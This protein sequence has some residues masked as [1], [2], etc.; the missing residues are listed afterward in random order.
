VKVRPALEQA[1]GYCFSDATLLEAALTHR[2]HSH[3]QGAGAA[4]NYERLE[5]LGDAL[6]GFLVADW[7]YR[8]DPPVSEGVL[9]RRRQTI[10]RQATLAE[11]AQGLGLGEA[12]RLGRGEES[13]GGRSKASLLADVFES[14]LGA[15]YLDGGIRPARAFV[16]RHLGS[17]L[18]VVRRS[19]ESRD[20]HKTRLQEAIQAR[21][22]RTPRYRIVSTSGP[23]HALEFN[24]EVLLDDEVL[25]SGRGSNRKR[26]EQAAAREA[27]I[28]LRKP[29]KN[30]R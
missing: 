5:F 18:Q 10:V 16:R 12:V 28:R 9:S 27:L 3:E 13:S 29:E 24:V 20:D 15:I 25:G 6:L 1:L 4:A 19:T 23:D 14:M 22:R 11:V 26:A 17:G 7:L 30:D 8:D 21:L 2:S